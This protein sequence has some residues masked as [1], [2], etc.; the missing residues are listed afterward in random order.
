MAPKL[1]VVSG[2]ATLDYVV[3][4]ETPFQGSGTVPAAVGVSGAWPRAGGAVLYASRRIAAAGHRAVAL[5]WLG[6]DGDGDYYRGACESAGICCDAIEQ[7]Q[8]TRT[9]RCI[10]IYQPDGRHGCLLD[11]GGNVGNES[12]SDRQSN[13]LGAANHICISVGPPAATAS[14]LETCP[15]AT[16][17]SWIA[18]LDVGAYPAALRSNLAARAHIIFCNADE[19]D[20]IESAR[21]GARSSS[22]IIIETHGSAGVRIDCRDGVRF[23]PA[24]AIRAYDA[25]GAGDT[26]AG[27]VIAQLLNAV[28]IDQAVTQG[29]LSARELLASRMP[30]H[31]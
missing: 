4:A 13:I 21:T 23:I 14:L 18:K 5:T 19:R 6:E 2:Y 20:F 26:L 24:N 12:L 31:G 25:T 15:Q 28:P 27:E 1:V 30:A 17:L 22:Q 16:G 11:A 9:T 7:R 8:G 10:L 3:Q 29:M